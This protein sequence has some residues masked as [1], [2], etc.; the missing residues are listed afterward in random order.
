MRDQSRLASHRFAYLDGLRGIAALMVVVM[1]MLDELRPMTEAGTFAALDWL[2]THL[3]D[4]GKIGVLVFFAISGFVIPS[5]FNNRDTPL[6]TFAIGRFFRLYPAYWISILSG[7]LIVVLS[8]EAVNWRDVLVNVTMLQRFANVP[9]LLG[10]YWTLQLELIFYVLCAGMF[11]ASVLKRS[12]WSGF[13]V[14]ALLVVAVAMSWLRY[15]YEIKLPVAVPLS[16]AIMFWGHTW[17][18]GT[19]S[20]D[21]RGAA[22]LA[23]L[24]IAAM[25]PVSL[26]AYNQNMGF[27]ETWYRY[28]LT[29]ALAILAFMAATRYRLLSFASWLGL[30][31]YST[32]LFHTVVIYLAFHYASR[33]FEGYG[34]PFASAAVVA[35]VVAVSAA[36]YYFVEKPMIRVGKGLAQSQG[37]PARE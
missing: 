34:M 10:I 5:S 12:L 32:Y 23:L 31:S 13:I 29:Y 30:V 35:L 14:A 37:L 33:L 28:F 21:R 11:V 24:Y 3:V 26:L 7:I 36:V 25:L 19:D 27:G 20:G 18:V 6:R 16:L 1:H 4:I 2:L 15:A 9:D 17:R 22:G 8:G